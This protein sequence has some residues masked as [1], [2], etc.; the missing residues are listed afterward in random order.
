M[1]DHRQNSADSRSFGPIDVA[2]VIGRAWLR[3]WPFDTFGILPTPTHPELD[4]PAGL[5]PS[6]LPSPEPSPSP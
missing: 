2:H 1:G 4:G 5:V 3:Y 6:P